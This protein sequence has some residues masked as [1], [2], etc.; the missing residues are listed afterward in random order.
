MGKVALEGIEFHAY[1]GAYPEE[2]IL[3]NRFTLDLELETN[4][5]KAMLE[6]D[7]NATVDYSKL[8]QIIKARMDVKV[9]LLEHL[10]HMIVTD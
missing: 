3:G 7:L 5:K 4:F 6:D 2:S 8:Y 10:G 9:K 1:H